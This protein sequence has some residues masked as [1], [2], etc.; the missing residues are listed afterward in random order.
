MLFFKSLE[1]AVSHALFPSGGYNPIIHDFHKRYTTEQRIFFYRWSYGIVLYE[2]LTVGRFI[3][4][5]TVSL[6]VISIPL[7]K[8]FT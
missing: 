5:F 2:I 4:I 8:V 1:S 3:P 7:Y 6:V